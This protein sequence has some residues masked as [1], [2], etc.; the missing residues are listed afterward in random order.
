MDWGR[1]AVAARMAVKG[2]VVSLT[3][4][5]G[6]IG[7]GCHMGTRT[8]SARDSHVG[9]LCGVSPI[10]GHQQVKATQVPMMYLLPRTM[11]LSSGR[12]GCRKNRVI[13]QQLGGAVGVY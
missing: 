2:N 3:L 9:L 12:K 4:E 6:E 7:W 1:C 11:I 10:L 13:Y 5:L 8:Y